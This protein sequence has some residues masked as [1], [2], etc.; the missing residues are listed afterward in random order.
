M[1][2]AADQD[3]VRHNHRLE[4]CLQKYS[5]GVHSFLCVL[6]KSNY[7]KDP[8]SRTI[9]WARMGLEG[10]ET[11]DA[12]ARSEQYLLK[13]EPN[14]AFTFREITQS[15]YAIYPMPC[16]GLTKAEECIRLRLYTKTLLC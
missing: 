10:K 13:W 5:T 15:S 16:K 4:R 14:P 11:A 8:T 12:S 6:Q 9:V 3:F 1:L 2:A 7:L